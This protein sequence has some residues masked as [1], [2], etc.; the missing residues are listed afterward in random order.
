LGE[1][2]PE[3][4][5]GPRRIAAEGELAQRRVREL[6]NGERLRRVGGC[7][8]DFLDGGAQAVLEV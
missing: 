3:K 1:H 6:A 4:A 7:F 5:L 8:L 2:Q